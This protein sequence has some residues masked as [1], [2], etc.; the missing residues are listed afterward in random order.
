MIA[1][2]ELLDF[3]EAGTDTYRFLSQVF[4]KELTEDAIDALEAQEWPRDAGNIHLDRGYSL[5]RRYFNFAAGDKRT[6]LAVEYARVFLATG[7]FRSEKRSPV[8]YES[9]FTSEEHIV[10]QE[11]R[12]EVVAWFAEDGFKVDPDLHEPEDHVAFEFEYLSTMNERARALAEA[13]DAEGLKR[14]VE[15]QAAFIEAHILNWV[16]TLLEVAQSYA[17]LA[18][19]LGMLEIA[20]GASEQQLAMLDAIKAQIEGGVVAA[21]EAAD[22]EAVVGAEAADAADEGEQGAEDEA[23]PSPEADL[24][25][26]AAEAEVA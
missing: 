7:V 19:Y 14:N 25:A 2:Q 6:Q 15:R 4:F 21:D 9:V 16:P 18:F 13:K 3:F 24:A 17:K 22:A 23:A 20:I 11:P 10:M 1:Q 8:P 12:D 5:V 26:G